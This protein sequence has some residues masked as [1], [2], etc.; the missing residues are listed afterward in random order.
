MTESEL[1]TRKN[2][3]YVE[4]VAQ[5]IYD[6]SVISFLSLI[7]S[8][9]ILAIFSEHSP[10]IPYMSYMSMMMTFAFFGYLLFGKRGIASLLFY[11]Y[12]LKRYPILDL[13]EHGRL[14]ASVEKTQRLMEHVERINSACHSNAPCVCVMKTIDDYYTIQMHQIRVMFYVERCVLFWGFRYA[15]PDPKILSYEKLKELEPELAREALERFR[16]REVQQRAR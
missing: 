13:E 10:F 11:K 1:E 8:C 6:V 9:I 12:W 14:P 2:I 7:L 15:D 4:R 3:L 16:T 5:I